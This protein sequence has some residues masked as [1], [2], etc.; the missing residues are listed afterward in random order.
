MK[1]ALRFV[2][3]LLFI[4][5]ASILAG[6]ISSLDFSNT[7]LLGFIGGGSSEQT[8]AAVVPVSYSNNICN[9]RNSSDPPKTPVFFVEGLNSYTNH[10]RL[11]TG[12]DYANGM[13]L[14][15]EMLYGDK[16]SG[17]PF[18]RYKVTPIVPFE[19]HIPVAKD[20]FYVT[21]NAK[22]SA[23]TSTYLI[24][25]LEESYVAFSSAHYVDAKY[26]AK[27]DNY[28]AVTCEKSGEIKKLAEEVTKGAK[29]D[30]ERAKMIEEYLKNN[31]EYG[32]ENFGNMPIYEFLFIKK[33]GVCK[34][35]ASAFVMMCRS[36][37]IP[38]RIVFGYLAKPVEYNQT[39]FAS[40][41]HAWAEVK[42]D[43]G[44]MEFDPTPSPKKI[45]T[46]TEVT[47]V[48]PVVRSGENLSVKGVVSS[49]SSSSLKP[50][51]YVE[52]YLKKDKK[53]KGELVALVPVKDGSF[54]TNIRVNTT[55]EYNVVA[56]YTGSML[57][58][59]SW[60]DPVVRIYG[61]PK[62]NLDI[63][64]RVA[65]GHCKIKG[66]V[67]M[68]KA[69]NG[70][71][72]LFV[73]GIKY[74]KKF[75]GS[76]EFNVS[77][78]KGI[79]RIKVYYPGSEEDFILPASFEKEVEAGDVKIGIDN[80]T[81]IAGVWRSNATV[82]FNGKPVDTM[83]LIKGE[84]VNLAISKHIETRVPM[85]GILNLTCLVPEF[86]YS[87]PFQLRVKEPTE[88]ETRVMGDTVGI[89]LKDSKG[90]LEGTLYV[91]GRPVFASGGVAKVKFNES[92]L[93]IYYPGDEFHLSSRAVI[94]KQLPLWLILIPLPAIAFAAARFLKKED[95]INFEF[96]M[97]NI[98]LPG[99]E[100]EVVV[101]GKGMLR[102]ALDGEYVGV[103]ENGLVFKAEFP[104]EGEH[105][106]VA[107]RL[108]GTKV[109]ER[110]ELK[111][112]ILDYRKAVAEIFGEFV[113]D[114]EDEKG[115]LKHVTAREILAGVENA[116]KILSLFEP[117]RYGETRGGRRELVELF[118]LCREVK[119]RAGEKVCLA[120]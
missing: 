103:G 97:P 14:E 56:H 116:Q 76:F 22:Y 4:L 84:G 28:L 89:Y 20:T 109:K 67:L 65:A 11:Y 19:K 12:K 8:P 98:W 104:D 82:Y 70:T 88:I 34:H 36:I 74:E 32:P 120:L 75:N 48:D 30:Y 39:V 35:F 23:K 53:E 49:T 60:S 9:L 96:Q 10:L 5:A 114:V 3:I 7:G 40:Q 16:G 25:K 91:N 110:K 93:E 68:G 107:E 37:D 50:S 115:S 54:S 52:I 55:G 80:L 111:F 27:D 17:T 61:T 62:I 73:D 86:G 29:N 45:K 71:I 64:D 57:F 119:K 46:S 79:H 47:Y 94:N 31:Y 15:E 69:V 2:P 51:G 77:L 113:E 87:K 101:R 13:W 106:L 44:W 21:A 24:D 112:K 90:L 33:R 81:A 63:S 38:A 78:T 1:D 105:I 95:T 92:R 6:F 99:D 18:T 41:A 117:A 43:A 42:F 72:Q 108:E 85:A 66:R 59:S 26:A 118:S 100:V 102:L 83:I 58:S